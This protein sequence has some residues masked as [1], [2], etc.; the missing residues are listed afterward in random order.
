VAKHAAKSHVAFDQLKVG[1]AD[2]GAEDA[3]EDFA[4]GRGRCWPA[5]V[6]RDLIVEHN[7]AHLSNAIRIIGVS[8]NLTDA[9]GV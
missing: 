8:A 7:S 5:L 6:D 1:L 4:V 2:A 9:T 3:N